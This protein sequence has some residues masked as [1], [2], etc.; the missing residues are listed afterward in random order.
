MKAILHVVR[1]ISLKHGR[2]RIG[3]FI[4]ELVQATPNGTRLL[5]RRKR[6]VSHQNIHIT[7]QNHPK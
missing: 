7:L 3:E 2:V 5:R 1:R 4:Q 6:A